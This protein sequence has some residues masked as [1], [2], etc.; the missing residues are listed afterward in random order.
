MTLARINGAIWLCLGLAGICNEVA[1]CRND[2]PLILALVVAALLGFLLRG[3]LWASWSSRIQAVILLLGLL[4][5]FWLSEG[6]G[7]LVN[8]LLFS[9]PALSGYFMLR[10]RLWAFWPLR[11]Q[12]ILLLF[13]VL[14]YFWLGE[15]DLALVGILLFSVWTL[16]VPAFVT[17]VRQKG[18]P[19]LLA[20]GSLGACRRFSRRTATDSFF[21]ATNTAPFMFTFGMVVVKLCLR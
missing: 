9:V 5:C 4:F 7:V 1:H 19:F 20:S 13:T 12:A 3:R 11:T 6:G 2:W 21:T 8:V 15:R 18:S 17:T 16:I 14:L 10:G